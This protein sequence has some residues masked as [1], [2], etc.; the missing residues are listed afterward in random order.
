M[1]V[2]DLQ[3]I[4]S[5]VG[6]TENGNDPFANEAI[7]L[8]KGPFVTYLSMHPARV[9]ALQRQPRI[10]SDPAG[11]S[12]Q[13]QSFVMC[14]NGLGNCA[15]QVVEGSVLYQ[16]R[17]LGNDLDNYIWLHAHVK[18][19]PSRLNDVKAVHLLDLLKLEIKFVRGCDTEW[20]PSDMMWITY[21]TKDGT[22][23]LVSHDEYAGKLSA[24]CQ[25]QLGEDG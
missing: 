23:R 20:L 10:V 6:S 4:Y 16:T 14:T 19:L 13:W 24:L 8:L 15:G 22:G 11:D 18:P 1:N 3:L 5:I 2:E 9:E 25:T 12:E 17:F 21:D 7:T